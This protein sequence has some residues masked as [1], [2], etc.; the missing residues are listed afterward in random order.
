MSDYIKQLID[1]LSKMPPMVIETAYLYA[2][3]YT[4]YG[5][6]VTKDWLTASQNACNLNRA[7]RDGYYAAMENANRERNNKEI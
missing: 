4:K 7:Y 1:K 2:I 5:V 6:D 3:N